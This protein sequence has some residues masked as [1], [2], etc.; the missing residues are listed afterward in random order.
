[1]AVVLKEPHPFAMAISSKDLHPLEIASFM[2]DF[3]PKAVV[4]LDVNE[5]C[6]IETYQIEFSR[7]FC[8]PQQYNWDVSAK[9]IAPEAHIDRFGRFK[10]NLIAVRTWRSAACARRKC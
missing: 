1:M 10:G 3:K 5:R 6:D 8:R 9:S 7:L 4:F 2:S